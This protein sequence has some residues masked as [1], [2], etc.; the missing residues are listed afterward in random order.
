[1]ATHVP[2]PGSKR[3]LMPNSHPAGA[4]NPVEITSVTVRV[5]SAGDPQSLVEK[6]YELAS[7]PLAKR[8]Y[9]THAELEEHHGAAQEDLDKIEHFAQQ[10]DLTVVHRSAAERSIVLKGKLGDLLAAF[11]ADVQIYQHAT[12]TYRG[13]RGEITVPQELAGIVTGVFGFDTRP[14]HRHRSRFAA[15]RKADRNGGT[16]AGSRKRA[17][18]SGPGGQNGV[19]ATEFAKH[20]NFPTNSRRHRPDHRHH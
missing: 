14:K 11:P 7:T 3:S 1:M 16:S 19:A 8:K 10:H 20:Y 18:R 5:R 4:I 15:P 12:G 13:R 6:A 17:A 9:L 2:L